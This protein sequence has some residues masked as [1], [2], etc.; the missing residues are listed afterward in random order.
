MGEI[1]GED[2]TDADNKILVFFDARELLT[3]LET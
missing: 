3:F 2:M 1:N